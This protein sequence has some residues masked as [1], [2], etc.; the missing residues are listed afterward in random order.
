[1]LTFGQLSTIYDRMANAAD[2]KAI[3]R[4]FGTQVEL[5]RSWLQTLSYCA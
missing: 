4:Q 3:A 2:Q 5:L 1:M